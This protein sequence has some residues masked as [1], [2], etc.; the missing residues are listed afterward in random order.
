MEHYN[1]IDDEYGKLEKKEEKKKR[2][3][4][5]F[6]DFFIFDEYNEST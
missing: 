5:L 2:S 6:F 4:I 1:W 3:N